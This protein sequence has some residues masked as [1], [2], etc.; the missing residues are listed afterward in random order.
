MSPFV[1][2]VSR[3]F[4]FF[5][6]LTFALCSPVFAATP[7]DRV[8]GFEG[9]AE[10]QGRGVRYSSPVIAEIDGNTANGKEIAVSTPDGVLNVLKSDGTLLWTARLPNAGCT[11]TFSGNKA[12]GA[13]AVGALYG[14]GV[15]YVVAPYGGLGARPCDGGVVAFVGSTGAVKWRF[16]TQ[17][18]AKRNKYGSIMFGVFGT[19]ALADVDG[20]GRLEIGFGSYDRNVYLLESNGRVRWFYNA[21]DTVWGSPT[22]ANVDSDSNLEMI[23]ATDISRNDRLVPATKNGGFVYAFKTKRLSSSSKRL[24]FRN[25]KAYV[26]MTY[27]EQALYSSPAVGDVLP[28]NPGDEVVIQSGCYFRRSSGRHF[29][30]WIKVLDVATGRILKTLPTIACSPSSPSLADVDGDGQLE[31]VATTSGSTNIGGDGVSRLSAWK[32]DNPTPLW[33]MTPLGTSRNDAGGGHFLSPV[34]ADLDGNGSLEVAVSNNGGVAIVAGATGE[35]LSCP[36]SSCTGLGSFGQGGVT[37]NTPAIGDVNDDG[38]LDLVAAGGSSTTGKVYAW[39][40]FDQGL[41]SS[42]G[43]ATPYSAPWPMWRKN[44]QRSAR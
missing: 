41:G 26:W 28:D 37:N 22:F 33:S 21:A 5:A 23:I 32:A 7:P 9:G 27:L 10:L 3:R 13:P 34:V 40:N 30:D 43:S 44:A 8:P 25:P 29:G 38:K 6:A 15:P 11:A 1:V 12:Y 19:P 31:I 42:A 4:G 16:S 17:A 24:G 35:Q 14:D 2:V 18:W 36:T 39:T 20:N